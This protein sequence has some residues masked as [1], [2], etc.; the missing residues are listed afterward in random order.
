MEL[1][2]KFEA[3]A[4]AL[5]T[6]C[7]QMDRDQLESGLAAYLGGIGVRSV[8]VDSER[9]RL[10][11]FEHVDS[12][13]ADCGVTDV[14]WG[15]ASTGTLAIPMTPDNRRT[16]SLVPPLHVALLGKEDLIPD[17]PMALDHL[18]HG[19]MKREDRP[20]SVV[21]VTGASRTA[22]IELDLVVGVHGP[23]ELHVVLF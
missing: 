19:M 3:A 13:R 14:L 5:A 11:A 15:I 18:Y 1:V 2:K 16:T 6:P 7:V 10:E 12:P 8:V 23:R 9:V 4:R 22:D 21:F 17:L 20:S